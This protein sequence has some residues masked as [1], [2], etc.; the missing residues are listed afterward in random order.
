MANQ[1]VYSIRLP[2]WTLRRFTTAIRSGQGDRTFTGSRRSPARCWVSGA[3]LDR[4]ARAIVRVILL[5]S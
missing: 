3:P 5:T 1:P 4:K 2:G